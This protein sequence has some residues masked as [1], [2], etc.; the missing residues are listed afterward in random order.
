MQGIAVE[1]TGDLLVID[2]THDTVVRVDAVTGDRTVISAGA[3]IGGDPALAGQRVL[4]LVPLGPCLGRGSLFQVDPATPPWVT[5]QL[6]DSFSEIAVE[7][8]GTVIGGWT[9]LRPHL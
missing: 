5:N 7:A 2:D 9:A 6:F 3:V 4:P 1:P 8:S